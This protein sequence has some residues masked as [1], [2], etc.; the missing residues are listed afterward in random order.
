MTVGVKAASTH[1]P[2]ASWRL[3]V[4]IALVMT[5]TIVVMR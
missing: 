2:T 1:R 4:L 3:Q 5:N